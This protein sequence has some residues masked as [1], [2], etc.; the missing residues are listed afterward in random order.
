MFITQLTGPRYAAYHKLYVDAEE[1]KSM[2]FTVS[3]EIHP[4]RMLV[5]KLL[6]WNASLAKQ[7]FQV[8]V[9]SWV[10]QAHSFLCWMVTV[11]LL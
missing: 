11:Q 1:H 2:P 3:R 10:H 5:I 7:C 8:T 9:L 6:M 4:H